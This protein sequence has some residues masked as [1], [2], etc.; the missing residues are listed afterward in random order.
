MILPLASVAI[1]MFNAKRRL[2]YNILALVSPSAKYVEGHNLL[3]PMEYC[4]PMSNIKF[5]YKYNLPTWENFKKPLNIPQDDVFVQFMQALHL[6]CLATLR[7][8]KVPVNEEAFNFCLQQDV[9]VR[10][11]C[12]YYGYAL[13]DLTFDK[14]YTMSSANQ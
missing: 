4:L 11:L 12:M 7:S 9:V 13:D 2:P 6:F 1:R 8:Y 5:A 3:W 14:R 10:N